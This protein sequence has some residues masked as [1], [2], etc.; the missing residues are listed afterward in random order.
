[1]FLDVK[2]VA[3]LLRLSIATIRKWVL[4]KYIPYKKIGSAVRF[5]VLEI[6]EWMES[7][8]SSAFTR[9]TA[10]QLVEENSGGGE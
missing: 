9:S 1:M 5:S 2:Q 10:K 7:K 8:S 4:I 6:Q 3:Q